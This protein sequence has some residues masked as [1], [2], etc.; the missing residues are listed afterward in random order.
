MKELIQYRNQLL[1]GDKIRL[2]GTT[3][4]DRAI[5]AKWWNE[6]SLLLG[7]RSRLFPTYEKKMVLV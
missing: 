7:N 1:Q 4:S 2:R 6:D 3:E 5:F